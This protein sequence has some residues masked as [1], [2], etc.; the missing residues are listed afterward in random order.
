MSS[1]H[2]VVQL[3]GCSQICAYRW[4]C[5][6]MRMTLLE[7]VCAGRWDAGCDCVERFVS[8]GAAA[9]EPAPAGLPGQ[10][11]EIA[12]SASG[13]PCAC[14]TQE[15]VFF[16]LSGALCVSPY[17]FLVCLAFQLIFDQFK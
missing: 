2:V 12:L 13:A 10:L 14:Q 8:L 11:F 17:L 7:A 16:S 5:V 3:H 4:A 15:K 6:L 1:L 9:P